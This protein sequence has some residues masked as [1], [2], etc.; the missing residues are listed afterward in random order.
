MATKK[1]TEVKEEE[2]KEVKVATKTAKSSKSETSASVQNQQELSVEDRLKS[3][4]QLQKVMS[5]I[6]EIKILRGDLPIEIQDLE[7]E[8]LGLHTRLERYTTEIKDNEKKIAAGKNAI[9]EAKLKL[10]KKAEQQKQVVNN[11]EYEILSKEIENLELDIQ[12]YEKNINDANYEIENKK[13]ELEAL[14]AHI[15]EKNEDLR[16]KKTELDQIIVETKK[17]EEDLRVSAKNLEDGIDNRLLTAF[18]RIR[19]NARN[20]L[21]VVPIERNACSGCFSK[22]PPQRQLDIRQRKKIIVCENCG[23]IIVDHEMTDE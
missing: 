9:E 5:K 12:I 18:K 19:K 17:E 7:D 2:V 1:K 8:V 22:V 6:D 15:E 10:D 21:A 13:S 20:G 14:S 16:L 23:R 11:R 4:Y 3:L